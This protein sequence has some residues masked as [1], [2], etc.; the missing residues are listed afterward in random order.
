MWYWI[1]Q[2]ITRPINNER[3]PLIVC[4]Q[5]A[6]DIEWYWV[7]FNITHN[8]QVFSILQNGDIGDI[9]IKCFFL[10]WKSEGYETEVI[11]QFHLHLPVVVT[12]MPKWNCDTDFHR[13][14]EK[15]NQIV[16]G[17]DY[18]IDCSLIS[19]ILNTDPTPAPPLH[20]RGVLGAPPTSPKGRLQQYPLPSI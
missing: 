7:I 8:H 1:S 13:L 11:V 20:G 12:F 16:R 5:K 19:E 10:R 18:L 15:K 2:H 4:W 6:C 14:Y 3:S 9:I 17:A